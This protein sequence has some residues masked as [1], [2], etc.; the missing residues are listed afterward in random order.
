MPNNNSLF[1]NIITSFAGLIKK[2]KIYIVKFLQVVSVGIGLLLMTSCSAQQL[3]TGTD[4]HGVSQPEFIENVTIAEAGVSTQK[5]KHASQ[6]YKTE[7]KEVTPIVSEAFT[8]VHRGIEIVP[9]EA[10]DPVLI[11]FIQDWYGVPYRLGGTTKRGIDCS[12]FV[13]RLYERVYDMDVVRTSRE[14]YSVSKKLKAKDLVEGDLV[15]FKI[16][17]RAI[18]HVGVYLG[19][20]KF[21][22]ASSSKGVMISDLDHAYWTR[23]YVGGGRIRA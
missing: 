5:V 19:D 9:G 2:S 10:C 16:R 17:S 8:I 21:V 15:F 23:Y 22:H 3:M 11:D 1:Y 6:S 4:Y 12:A 14:Q 7:I 13:Q 20:G 18:S